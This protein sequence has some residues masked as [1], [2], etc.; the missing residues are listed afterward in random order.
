MTLTHHELRVL[1]AI[2]EHEVEQADHEPNYD[3][4][5]REA[6]GAICDKVDAALA[7]EVA[8]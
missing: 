1:Q 8:Q 6:L 5:D 7:S 2:L 3:P 4:A